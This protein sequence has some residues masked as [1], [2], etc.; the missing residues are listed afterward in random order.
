MILFCCLYRNET[1]YR[2]AFNTAAREGA[3]A[4]YRT[5][6]NSRFRIFVAIKKYVI[7]IQT[8]MLLSNSLA[9][10]AKLAGPMD[11]IAQDVKNRDGEW[12]TFLTYN[13]IM[14]VNNL[15]IKSD[16]NI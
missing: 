6:H 11:L 16:P 1:N 12:A 13:R 15:S 10:N 14:S 3:G 7:E 4:E 5:S 2:V 9:E 8:E